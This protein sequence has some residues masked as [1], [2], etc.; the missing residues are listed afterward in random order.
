MLPT[1]LVIYHFWAFLGGASR[2]IRGECLVDAKVQRGLGLAPCPPKS[3]KA[4]PT[5]GVVVCRIINY[6]GTLLFERGTTYATTLPQRLQR[7]E[8]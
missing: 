7:L 6:E 4:I 3:P 1:P 5:L 8:R 2:S